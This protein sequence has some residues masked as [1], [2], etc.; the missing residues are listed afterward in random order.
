MIMARKLTE[1]APHAMRCPAIACPRR[2]VTR[3]SVRQACRAFTRRSQQVSWRVMA[4]RSD[5]DV[6][7]TSNTEDNAMRLHHHAIIIAAAAVLII[8]LIRQI[9]LTPL[10][11]PCR[12]RL[13]CGQDP[14]AR[15][16]R[17]AERQRRSERTTL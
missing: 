3:L 2:P 10:A 9:V 4:E 8:S 16:H 14:P 15:F 5:A 7:E 11:R 12:H 1:A 13:H 17:R 6:T